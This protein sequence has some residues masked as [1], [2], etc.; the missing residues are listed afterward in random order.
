MS[1][2]FT[3]QS[4]EYFVD[5]K[6]SASTMQVIQVTAGGQ[7]PQIRLAPFFGAFKQ[8]KLGK[9]S[10]RLVPAATLPV[11]PTG[12]SY[13][14]GENTIDP[15]DQFN[16]GLVRITNGED[17]SSL[18]S[19]L[20]GTSAE[21]S[22]Y[23]TL[24]DKRWYKFALQ[25]GC[26]R[27]ATPLVWRIGQSHQSIRQSVVVPD[28]EEEGPISTTSV[29]SLTPLATGAFSGAMGWEN[30]LMQI[31]RARLSWMPT[32]MYNN[33]RYGPNVV[34]E[35]DVMTLILPKAYKTVYYYRMYI[36][37]E[38]M[39][40][41][42]VAINPYISTENLSGAVCSGAFDRFLYNSL[43]GATRGDVPTSSIIGTGMNPIN[44]GSDVI[45]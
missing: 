41:D 43:P 13:E 10:I 30:A 16:P 33:E 2:N 14:A 3:K 29:G 9:V 5:L 36:R 34:P 12:L 4:Y 21:Q 6:T 7:M 15:R 17:V 26:K 19:L 27:T 31:D 8:F 18:A 45:E 42:P 37:E 25:A 1:S 22:Y 24:L 11:D 40:K 28:S 32:D 20:S 38:V 39:F 35:I 23:A 44:G